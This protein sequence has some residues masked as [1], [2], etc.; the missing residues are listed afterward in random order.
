MNSKPHLI[1]G[2]DSTDPAYYE[3]FR[4]L[5]GRV[6]SGELAHGLPLDLRFMPCRWRLRGEQWRNG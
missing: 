2:A 4:R 3:A 6:F 1:E 5:S